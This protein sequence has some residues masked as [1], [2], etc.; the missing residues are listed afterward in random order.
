MDEKSKREALRKYFAKPFNPTG[1]IILIVAGGL[2]ALLGAAQGNNGG[3]CL[4]VGIVGVLLGGLIWVLGTQNTSGGSATDAQVDEWFAQDAK[5][6]IQQS[7]DKLGMV[8]EQL[9]KDPLLITG[10]ILWTTTG[11]PTTDLLWKKGK[12]GIVRF[13]IN[14]V[15]I[16]QLTDQLLGAYACDFNFLKNVT[17]NE[18]TDE[19][20]YRDVVSVSTQEI[21]TSYTLP[22]GIK[23]V[24]A[25]AF[26]LAVSSGDHIDVTINA[27]ELAKITQGTIPT[28]GAE[29]AVAAIR[30]MLREKKQ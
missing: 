27:A 9:V 29:K 28:T 12:D 18:R 19:Y 26:R 15:T 21:A 30:A 7:L 16:V 13:A 25:Q 3:G 1:A 4:T 20:H 24:A 17:L 2:F 23:M 8:K 6:I 14:R 5:N 11:I 10:P 22:T